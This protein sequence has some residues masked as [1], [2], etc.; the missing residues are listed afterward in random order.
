MTWNPIAIYTTLLKNPNTKWI[1][2]ILTFLY[3]ISPI[4]LIPDFLLPFGLIDD[5]LILSFLI[6]ALREVS[7]SKRHINV[8]LK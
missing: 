4:D 5:G 3:I 1:T 8:G 7:A 6:I 2:I